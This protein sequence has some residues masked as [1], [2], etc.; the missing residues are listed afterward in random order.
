VSVLRRLRGLRVAE[1]RAESDSLPPQTFAGH[2]VL[3]GRDGAP[4]ANLV[5]HRLP[6]GRWAARD[7]RTVIVDG[8]LTDLFQHTLTGLRDRRL[9]QFSPLDAQ[10]IRIDLPSCSGELVRAGGQWSFPNPAAG[11]IDP[12]RAA[13]FV[14]ALRALTW[15]EPAPS[16]HSVSSNHEVLIT[17]AEGA[18]LDE[19]RI[20]PRTG[21]SRWYASG[22]SSGGTRLVDPAKF[23]HLAALFRALG[24]P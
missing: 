2:V 5:F 1:F 14:R 8:D 12:E 17:G 3:W 18:I 21:A 4:L 23:E 24:A 9:L 16:P 11:R 6:D 20:E 10:R 19:V 13:G 7:G 15:D 22:R